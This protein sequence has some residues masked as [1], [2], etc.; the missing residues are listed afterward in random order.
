MKPILCLLSIAIASASFAQKKFAQLDMELPTPNEYRNAAGAPGHAYF[1]QQAD[2]KMNLVLDDD[3]QKLSGT[4][5]ITYTNNSPDALPYLWLQLDQNIYDEH[6]DTKLIEVE[7]MEDFKSIGDIQ[8]RFFH[9][10]GGFKVESISSTSGQPMS[11]FINKTMLRIDLATPLAPKSSISFT[12]KWWYNINDR[13]AV[14]GRSGYEY[15]EKDKNYLYTLAQFF[16]RMCVY[17]DVTGWQNKQFLGRG[18]FTLPFGNYDVSITV[19]SDHII[20]AT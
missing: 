6:S 2:Y 13:M 19:P 16:P 1:Q 17:S 11:Y 18:E 4:E 15:F 9:Y 7:K 3:K 5:T 10:D 12:V 8:K 14:G 20:A